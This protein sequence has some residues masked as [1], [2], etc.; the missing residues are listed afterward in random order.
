MVKAV[1]RDGDWAWDASYH[2]ARQTV[3]FAYLVTVLLFARSGLYAERAQR[4]GLSR[5]VS[6]LF[7]VTVVALIFALVNGEHVLELLHLLRH[8]LL[9]DHHHRL[10]AL[11]LRAAH[12]RCCCAPRATAAARCSSA[13][14]GTSRTSRTR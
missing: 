13:R 9:R 5:I 12:R 3:A 7:Q 4:P 11:G 2:E 8:A 10:A 1:L 14:A 6:S